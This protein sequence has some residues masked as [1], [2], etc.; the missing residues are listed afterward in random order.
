ME[1]GTF[2]IINNSATIGIGCCAIYTIF[3]CNCSQKLYLQ[4]S[5]CKTELSFENK[6]NFTFN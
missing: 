6:L 2:K 3:I 4:V 1:H 5:P